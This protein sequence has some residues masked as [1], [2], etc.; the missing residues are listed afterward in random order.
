M[1]K[2]NKLFQTIKYEEISPGLRYVRCHKVEIFIEMFR[3]KLQSLVWSRP[4]GKTGEQ[5]K[6][7]EIT[8]AIQATDYLN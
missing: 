1:D 4:A 5:C 6:H 8:L 2:V 3:A 7:L